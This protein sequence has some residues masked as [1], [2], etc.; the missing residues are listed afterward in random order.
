MGEFDI[1]HQKRTLEKKLAWLHKTKSVSPA[2]RK[3]IFDFDQDSVARGLSL[4]RR[5]K[6]LIL[7]SQLSKMLKGDLKKA[8]KRQIKELSLIHI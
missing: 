8:T 2:D 6:Y 5:I 3:L 4:C 1:H 7:L